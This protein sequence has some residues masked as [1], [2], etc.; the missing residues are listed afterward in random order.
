[1]GNAV[2]K[3]T[4][5]CAGAEPLGTACLLVSLFTGTQTSFE[6]KFLVFSIISTVLTLSVKPVICKCIYIYSNNFK[7]NTEALV[8]G[9]TGLVTETIDPFTGILT[10]T[11]GGDTWRAVVK[12]SYLQVVPGQ[13][14]IVISVEGCTA[15]VDFINEK[16]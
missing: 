5:T 8:I 7:T 14:V 16:S 13:K 4:V 10:I 12:N 1:M 15:V 9:K 6:I 11:V 3:V 2:A